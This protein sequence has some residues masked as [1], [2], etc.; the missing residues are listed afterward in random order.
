M[1]YKRMKIKSILFL[2]L[3]FDGLLGLSQDTS[4]IKGYT[5]FKYENGKISSE[6]V[7]VNDKP[8]GYWKTF[9]E[10]GK[11]KSEGNRKNFEIDSLWKF[12]NEEI[13]RASCRERE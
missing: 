6:G 2:F 13:G 10:N 3:I 4:K 12:Y 9:Y 7:L 8:D 11:L 1:N 5:V